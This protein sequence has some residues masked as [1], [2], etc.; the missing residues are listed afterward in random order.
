MKQRNRKKNLAGMLVMA[1]ALSFV[2]VGC[3]TSYGV[4]AFSQDIETLPLRTE[5]TIL[6]TGEVKIITSYDGMFT[7]TNLEEALA[8]ANNAGFSKLLS[9]EYGMK[10]YYLYSEKWVTIRCAKT[11]R[12]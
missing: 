6:D 1:L 4:Q 12:R 2:L 11:T 7:A 5:E 3:V 8:M 10:T 9:I